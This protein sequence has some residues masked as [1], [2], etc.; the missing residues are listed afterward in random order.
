MPKQGIWIRGHLKNDGY[1]TQEKVA[2]YVVAIV[3]NLMCSCLCG[4]IISPDRKEEV[5]RDLHVSMH[6]S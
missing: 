5:L 1:G 3:Q 2:S 6:P 4:G